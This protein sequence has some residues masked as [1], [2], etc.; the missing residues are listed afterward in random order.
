MFL[1]LTVTGGIAGNL[2]NVQPV[3][4][5]VDLQE[6][7]ANW[8]SHPHRLAGLS[9]A[10]MAAQIVATPGNVIAAAILRACPGTGQSWQHGSPRR[11]GDLAGGV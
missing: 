10:Q 2:P 7:A 4:L 1:S 8:V 5:S 11:T 9:P 3:I 6:L